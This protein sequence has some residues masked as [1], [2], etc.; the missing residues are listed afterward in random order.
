M[1]TDRQ[2]EGPL[3]SLKEKKLAAV[4]SVSET[5]YKPLELGGKPVEV[6]LW[7]GINNYHCPECSFDNT[8]LGA[9]IYHHEIVHKKTVVERKSALVG[10]D[11]NPV[12]VIEED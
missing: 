2:S 6:T 4:S 3:A 7:S 12:T 11:G 10:A 1:K 9:L 8:D 5:E